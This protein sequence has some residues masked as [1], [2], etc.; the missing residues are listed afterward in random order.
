MRPWFTDW[1]DHQQQIYWAGEMAQQWALCVLPENM[2]FNFPPSTWWL[3]TTCN[4]SSRGSD[5]PFFWGFECIKHASDTQTAFPVELYWLVLCSYLKRGN[6]WPIH[7]LKKPPKHTKQK[8]T[9]L[10]GKESILQVREYNVLLL[11]QQLGMESRTCNDWQAS[12]HCW[13]TPQPW[14]WHF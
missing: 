10:K 1:K 5:A 14:K 9:A 11:H 7:I 2:G 3:T 12:F 4:S 13:A 8:L 6:H